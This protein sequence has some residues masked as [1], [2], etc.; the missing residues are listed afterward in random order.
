MNFPAPPANLKVAGLQITIWDRKDIDQIIKIHI[1]NE[2]GGCFPIVDLCASNAV[3]P[4]ETID[5]KRPGRIGM[6]PDEFVALAKWAKKLC[7][8]V[9]AQG[10]EK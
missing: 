2:G 7:E 8:W 10:D 9:D 1:D 4:D 5:G 6:D 3:L